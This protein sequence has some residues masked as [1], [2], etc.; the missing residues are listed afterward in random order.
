MPGN[1][2]L[3]MNA[4]AGYLELLHPGPENMTTELQ[5][6]VEYDVVVLFVKDAEELR[7]FG[8]T[9][10]HAARGTG[11]LWIT[12]PKGGQSAGAT[13]LPATPGWVRTDVLGEITSIKGYKAVA[14][15]AVDQA[16]T[17]LRFKRV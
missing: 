7:R 6:D 15:V 3:V 2:V 16:W 12:Y 14:F 1:S 5:P 17:A 13:D 10:I 8:K 4:P 11:L 9:A